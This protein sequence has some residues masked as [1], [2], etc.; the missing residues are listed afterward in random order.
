M[1]TLAPDWSSCTRWLTEPAGQR[2]GHSSLLLQGVRC[3]AC[4]PLVERL[5]RALPGVLDVQANAAS[6]RVQLRWDPERTEPEAWKA[7]LAAEGYALAPDEAA[8]A[9]QLRQLEARG[10]LWRL[11]VAGL[12]G[13]QVMMLAAPSYGALPG[14]LDAQWA[15]LL[16]WGQWVLSVP[17]MLFAARPIFSAAARSLAQR[18]LGMDVPVALALLITFVASSAATVDPQGALGGEVY[19]DSL[20]MF[21]TLL[22]LAR[23]LEMRIRHHAAQA[24]EASH[25][26]LPRTAQRWG[27]AGELETVASVALAPGDR[28]LV[29]MGEAVPADGVLLEGTAELDEALLSGE[30]RPVLKRAG[31]SGE[32]QVWAG[33]INLGAS[34]TMR[35][36]AAASNTR[37]AEVEALV[38]EAQGSKPEGMRWLDNWATVFVF[39]VLM[40]AVL[41]AV[42]WAFMDPSRVGPVVVAVLVVTCPCAFALALPAAQLAAAQA[43]ARHGVIVRRMAGFDR[44]AD[45]SWVIFDKTGTLSQPRAHELVLAPVG[46]ASMLTHAEL[47][48]HG[49]ALAQCSAHA[50]SR[51]LCES[52]RQHRF[53]PVALH[54]VSEALGQG[55]SGFDDL[56][57]EWRLGSAAFAGA[58]ELADASLVLSC[59]GRPLAQWHAAEQPRSDAPAALRSLQAAGLRC[60]VLSGDSAER[61]QAMATA[62]G[63]SVASAAATPE[64]KL[65]QLRQLRQGGEVVVMVGDGFN[66]A[67]VLAAAD[68]AVVLNHGAMASQQQADML[69][70]GNRIDALGGLPRALHLARRARH[71]ARQ[72]LLW[73][74]GYNLVC[75]PLALAGWLPPWAAG[76]GMAISSLLVVANAARLQR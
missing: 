30:S 12:C 29:P 23:W 9:R 57:R 13:M 11:F 39:A 15:R 27:A 8:S 3:A 67:A 5:L 52:A 32:A 46:D 76:L 41:A 42:A 68:V 45:A 33:A 48:A 61:V 64:A 44:L 7:A 2:I 24:L 6:E 28:V 58:P 43:L 20:T 37:A 18:R 71:I 65:Q 38:R 1:T 60:S 26:A 10:A 19:F 21:V 14:E 54:K 56:R 69:L 31:F 51:Q 72:N 4:A 59:N 22:L 63:L 47:W 36:L 53:A 34:F 73:A 75:V 62:L 17:V 49:T 35:V 50:R 74:A 40:L 55:V 16:N 66:D 70:D 25:A